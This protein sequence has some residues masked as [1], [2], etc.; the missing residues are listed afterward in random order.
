MNN[1]SISFIPAQAGIQWLQWMVIAKTHCERQGI[2][3]RAGMT[4]GGTA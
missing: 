3:A 2:P 1:P 4:I